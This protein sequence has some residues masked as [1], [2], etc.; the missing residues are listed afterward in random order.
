VDLDTAGFET[1]AIHAGQEPDAATGAVAVP[2]YQTS[3]FRQEGISRHF[4]YEYART[5]NPTRAALERCLASLEGAHHGMAFASGMAAMDAVLRRLGPADHLILPRQ[6]YGGTWRLVTS[7]LPVAFDAVD[8]SDLDAL[9]A[10]WRPETRLVLVES[11]T[12][13]TLGIVDIA[14]VAGFAHQ[15][16]ALCVVDN[17]FA[18]PYL[19]TPLALGADVVV[20]STTKYLGGHSDVIGGFVACDDDDLAAAIGAVQRAA[21]AVPGPL[22]CFLVLRGVKTLALRMERHCA[23]AEAVVA[24]LE[25]HPAVGDVLYPGRPSHPGHDVAT[26]QMRRYGGMVAVALAGGEA[27]ARAFVE[28]TRLFTLGESLGGVESL[29]GYPTTMSHAAMAGTPDAI[30]PAI[31]RLSVGIEDSDDLVDDLRQA[32]KGLE[33]P[34]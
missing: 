26:R 7:V 28:R 4:G 12:N 24:F 8:Q 33:P 14:A 13:P 10:A 34:G 17:T 21:G 23:N 20:H 31:V 29:I 3:T 9:D 2:I 5:S 1:R 27:A 32:L 11:P 22:D 30:D 25:G 18:T 6:G 16:G 15:R 19:Q